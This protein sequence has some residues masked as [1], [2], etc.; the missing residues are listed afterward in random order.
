MQLR[1]IT[2]LGRDLD[3]TRY[4]QHRWLIIIVALAGVAYGVFTLVTIGAFFAAVVAGL[5]AGVSATF[6]WVLAR[7]LD[8]DHPPS[9]LVA[10][11]VGGALGIAFPHVLGLAVLLMVARMVNCTTG[12]SATL[13]DTIFVLLLV[14]GAAFL[15]NP[16]YAFIGALGFLLDGVLIN[17]LPR[18]RVVAAVSAL[19][20]IAAVV[21]R[22][23]GSPVAVTGLGVYLVAVT[24][25]VFGWFLMTLPDVTCKGDH[26]GEVH[27]QRVQAAG[28]VQIIA[29]VLLI[30][31]QGNVAVLALIP[32]WAAMLGPALWRAASPLLGGTGD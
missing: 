32:L 12:L 31:W 13:G 23:L 26:G 19:I 7:E 30:A 1:D 27:R 16:L 28:F 21:Y 8:P 5:V 9:A 14:A 4:P 22:P 25:V 10:A 18:H 20:G 2:H 24:I 15:I 6:A 17:P 29:A 11:V 3:P